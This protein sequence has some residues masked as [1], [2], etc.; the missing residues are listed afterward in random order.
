MYQNDLEKAVL[1]HLI[2]YPETFYDYIGKISK[3]SFISHPNQ[4]I[5]QSLDK[6]IKNGGADFLSIL[7][8]LNISGNLEEVG[9]N[10]YVAE[11]AGAGIDKGKIKSYIK[12]LNEN[13][14]RYYL[15]K[16]NW[17][18]KDM[19]SE[20]KTTDDILIKINDIVTN[21]NEGCDEE[22]VVMG[23]A[24]EDFTK[25]LDTPIHDNYIKTGLGKFDNLT[26]GFEKS[27]LVIV[28]GPTSMGKTSFA[29]N[30]MQD[31][32][33][34]NKKVAIFSLEMTSQQIM[35]RVVASDAQVDVRKIKYRDFD[36]REKNRLIESA[37][38]FKSKDLIIDDVTSS[39]SS[40]IS[41]CKK[42]KIRNGLDVVVIDYLQ[43]VSAG[44]NKGTREQEVAKVVRS[45]KNLA[46]ELKIVVIALSQLSRKIDGREG[47][48]I[49]VLGD[50]RESGEIEQSADVVLFLH[51]KNYY[52][53]D[54][55]S[56]FVH[57]TDIIVAKGRNIG[58]G[59]TN[60][61][62]I[63]SMTKF[64]DEYKAK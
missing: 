55:M 20:G 27:D 45:L 59:R 12:L 51:R 11:V 53:M 40:I 63:P 1:G 16:M 5:F 14:K 37:T 26:G 34:E 4:L 49:P 54:I 3:S 39:L 44:R 23:K 36:N 30:I 60:S 52:D 24:V 61:L 2:N 57:S 47:S 13:R 29:L 9:G 15:G 38:K 31:M 10:G 25:M 28:A 46:K 50:L 56:E 35:S 18:I 22:E 6:C 62:F 64:C 19:L 32:V 43:L 48:K 21:L 8:D 17:Y 58:T 42:F 33:L 41:K 7:A